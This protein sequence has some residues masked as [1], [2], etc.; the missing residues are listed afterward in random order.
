MA[1]LTHQKTARLM[2]AGMRKDSLSNSSCLEHWLASY[3]Q[4]PDAGF[5]KKEH[6]TIAAAFLCVMKRI[7]PFSGIITQSERKKGLCYLRPV[8]DGS[9]ADDSL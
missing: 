5:T 9:W 7:L 1:G 4:S 6:F 2:K 8:V 3:F